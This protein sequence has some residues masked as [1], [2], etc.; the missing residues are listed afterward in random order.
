[1]SKIKNFFLTIW[2]R[3]AV[4]L[5]IVVIGVVV[6]LIFGGTVAFFTMFGLIGLLVAFV[7]GRQLYWWITKTGDYKDYTNDKD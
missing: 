4:P 7:F 1:M 5:L 6:G 2:G 3:F